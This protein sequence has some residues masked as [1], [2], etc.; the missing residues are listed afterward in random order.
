MSSEPITFEAPG[1]G[2]WERDNSHCPPAA[3]PLYQRVASF[4]MTETYRDVFARWGGPLETMEVRFVNG[5]MFRR[6]VPLIGAKRTGPPPPRPVLWLAT[7]LHP[8]FR[9]RERAARRTLAERPYLDAIDHWYAA[10]RQEWI[11]RNLAVQAVDPAALDDAELATHLDRLDRHLVD[12][13]LRHHDLHGSDLG[14]IGDLLA[15]GA[16]W[17]LDPVALLGLLHGASPASTEG[18][19]HGRRIAD[20]LRRATID[21]A[22]VRT[23]AEVRA[24]PTA[25]AAL[26]DYLQLFGWRVVTSYDV[27]GLTTGELPSATCALIRSCAGDE[28]SAL[29]PDPTALRALVPAADR[30]RFDELLTDARKA[31]GVRDDNGPLT[32]EWPMGLVRRAFLE[33]GRRLAG[34]GRLRDA[35]HVFEL[36]TPEVAAALLDRPAPSADEAADRAAL[37]VRQAGVEAPPLL[38]PAMP[39][40]DVT[41]FP[42]GMRRTMEIVLATVANLE[43]DPD[44][45]DLH[46][47]GIGSAVHRGVARVAVDPDAVLDVMQPGDVLVAPWTAPT[48]NAVLAIA[49][50]IVVQEGGLLCHAAVMARELGI[51]AVIGCQRAMTLIGDGDVV[52][53]DPGVGEVRIVERGGQDG[54][55]PLRSGG[56]ELGR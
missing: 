18:R 40:P 13:W 32:A 30:A 29:I 26:D 27:E 45:D 55:A 3:T 4:T 28:A 23:I 2:T 9:K 54:R 24:D 15:H 21:P 41:A 34:R 35:R 37:R 33:S 56:G 25:S 19:A 11:D 46:G 49:G 10:E 1:P 12:G 20:A 44:H 51:P 53:V 22:A 47:L 17:G 31:Y 50:G 16:G 52:D 39:P 36:D 7:R 38:G 8:A 6:L 42:P 14:P 48:Y 5:K 43:R